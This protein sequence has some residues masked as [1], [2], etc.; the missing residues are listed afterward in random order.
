MGR[1]LGAST[2]AR[3]DGG[4]GAGFSRAQ[5]RATIAWQATTLATIGAIVG[6]PA[7]L[8]VGVQ[9]RQR[10]ADSLGVAP[11][12]RIP[13]LLVLAQIP[14]VLIL[15]N[16]IAFVPARTAARTRPSVALRSE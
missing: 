15:V 1:L 2:I 7:G 9:I 6:I 13:A 14:I 10:V 4:V 12:P 8:I 3:R 5:V 11:S 16:L